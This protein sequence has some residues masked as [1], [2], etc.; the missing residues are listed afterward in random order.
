M[1]EELRFF[2]RTGVYA[3]V[4][5]VVYWFASYD[6]LTDSYDWAGTT[7]LA[8]AALAGIA[9]VAVMALFARR[10]L[11]GRGGSTLGILARWM[12]LGDPAGTADDAPLAAG[13][14]P[15]PPSSAWPLVGGVA[16]ALIGLGLVFGPW[17]WLPG[18]VLLA[19]TAWRWVTQLRS[20]R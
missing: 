12:G 19:W 3:A 20:A 10:A 18:A 11:G 4:I 15:L 17:L 7:L 2:L 16:A 9:V 5:A 8:A 14:D 13:L 1:A 6:P